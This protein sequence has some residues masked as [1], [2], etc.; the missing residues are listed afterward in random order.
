MEFF[1]ELL[2]AALIVVGAGFALV[3]SYGLVKLPEMMMRLHTPTKATTLGVGSIL[4]ASM[5]YFLLFEGIFS[6]HQLL[7]TL[8]LFIAAPLTAHMMSKVYIHRHSQ[9]QQLPPP[10]RERPAV[11]WATLDPEAEQLDLK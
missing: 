9:T 1:A 11:G 6:I 5:L 7:I 4:I 8:F 2:V 10:S 3:G